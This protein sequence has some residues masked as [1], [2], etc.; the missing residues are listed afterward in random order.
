MNFL[1][2]WIEWKG[3]ICGWR[4]EASSK[5]VDMKEEDIFFEV[6]LKEFSFVLQSLALKTLEVEGNDSLALNYAELSQAA[7]KMK[8]RK[9]RFYW[10]E[11][12]NLNQSWFKNS[13]L[14]YQG[15][16]I[17]WFWEYCKSCNS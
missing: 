13:P 7:W 15:G 14:D 10:L 16:I 4:F 6:R 2:W 8:L 1:E 5:E 17:L 3:W 11:E 12:K 9:V